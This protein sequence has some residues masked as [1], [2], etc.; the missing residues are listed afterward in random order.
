MPDPTPVLSPWRQKLHEIIFEADTPYGKAFD[1][2]L[3]LAIIASVIVVCLDSV[4]SIREEHGAALLA[5]ELFLTAA[6][7]I[8]YVLRLSCVRRPLRYAVSFFGVIDL[9]AIL[10]TYLLLLGVSM[11]S[12]LVIRVLRLLR[13][14]RVFKLAHFIG[15]AQALR[16][17]LRASVYKITVF[18][19][20]VLSIMLIMGTTMYLV[21]GER[22]GFTN[23]PQSVYWAIVTM[24][25]VGYGDITPQ[26]I[27]GKFV[28]SFMM[29]LGYAILAVPT[30]I[31]TV[32]L[33]RSRRPTVSGQACPNCGSDG[34]DTDARFC[35]LCASRL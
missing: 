18:L 27:A 8:E 31:V 2:A 9:M 11:Q 6:F 1:V 32:E 10:P 25:T 15:E 19:L 20:A 12:L 4:I 29:M 22:S 34:H 33:S 21:E 5:G 17:A 7:T 13:V 23:I 16:A 30:G 14:F 3:L 24:T 28:A 26:S 35:K